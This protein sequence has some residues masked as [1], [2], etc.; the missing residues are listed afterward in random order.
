MLTICYCARQEEIFQ[1]KRFY[2]DVR[3]KMSETMESGAAGGL[4]GAGALMPLRRR[5]KSISGN[6]Y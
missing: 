6:L 5:H 1:F 2:E 3:A 4:T